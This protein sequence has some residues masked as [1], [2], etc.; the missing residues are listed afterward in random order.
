MAFQAAGLKTV[1]RWQNELALKKCRAF[2]EF[3]NQPAKIL[4]VPIRGFGIEKGFF[5]EWPHWDSRGKAC[6]V[7]PLSNTISRV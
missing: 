3:P 1:R 7:L 2:A 4:N 6:S 5:S